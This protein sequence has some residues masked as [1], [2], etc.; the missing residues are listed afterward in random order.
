MICVRGAITVCFPDGNEETK[1]IT[2]T[3][4][5]TNN[6]VQN[7]ENKTATSVMYN[8]SGTKNAENNNT[9]AT[10]ETTRPSVIIN[11]QNSNNSTE[12]NGAV[13]DQNGATAG[14][15]KE[16]FI[17]NILNDIRFLKTN[18]VEVAQRQ[19]A[20]AR[21]FIDSLL[22]NFAQSLNE[23][24]IYERKRENL[25]TYSAVVKGEDLNARLY[26]NKTNNTQNLSFS[27]KDQT[28]K[29][30]EWISLNPNNVNYSLRLE[31]QTQ[32]LRAYFHGNE[33]DYTY[34]LVWKRKPQEQNFEGVTIGSAH[35]EGNK[36]FLTHNAYGERGAVWSQEKVDLT[37]DFTVKANLYLGD[38]P[39]G[40]DGIAFVIQN[41]PQGRNALGM[42]GGGLGYR[43]ITNSF[44]VEFDT[45]K[46]PGEI[47]GNHIGF[48]VNGK[49][50]REV[51]TSEKAY[52]LPQPLESGRE[53]PVT[54][55]WDY[56]G[57]NRAEVTV[58]IFNQTYKYAIDNILE[59]FGGTQAYIGFTGATGGERNLQYVS[60]VKIL[61]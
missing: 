52:A 50:H 32:K 15:S 48:D 30:N 33:A 7:T 13:S 10:S 19:I 41:S 58:N 17:A 14:L 5:N 31:T 51:A 28:V 37:K 40:A 16:G 35:R 4:S 47:N 9:Q 34:S 11:I 38:R 45:W 2:P 39:Q 49:G 60:N 27:Y 44:A 1:T 29:V 54:I 24:R 8:P 3:N 55:K 21:N 57:N 23:V 12:N 53:I 42:G 25:Y 61:F 26:Y 20:N 43:G 18:P 36:I 6:N 46:N 56:K 22:N 59:V